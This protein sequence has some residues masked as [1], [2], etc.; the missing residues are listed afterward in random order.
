MPS[1]SV[2]PP[3]GRFSRR[4]RVPERRIERSLR[5]DDRDLRIE[6]FGRHRNSGNQPA[7]ADRNDQHLEIGH[8]FEHFQRDRALAGD[9]V[10]V[11]VRM[12]PGQIALVRHGF[13]A[14]LRLRD[15][16]TVQHDLGAVG[17]GR[18]HLHER[19]RHRHHHARRNPQARSVIRHRLGMIAGRHGDHA[20]LA[21]GFVQ[22]RK[23]AARAA[24]LERVGDLEI[25]VFDVDL[26]AGQRRQF[27]RRQHRR[28]QHVSG[29]DAASRFDVGQR[30]AH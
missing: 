12:H 6:R 21:F 19:R 15:A 7:A 25:L 14:R 23:L 3:S 13:G 11:V 22:R 2:E 20:A 27:R 9:D 28:G 8:V 17:L 16:F 4:D 24:L 29:D 1:A 18:R 10:L 26:G 30:D 5:A